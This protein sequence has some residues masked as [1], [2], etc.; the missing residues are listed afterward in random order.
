MFAPTNTGG[1]PTFYVMGNHDH[2]RDH[3][4]DA[5]ETYG[6]DLTNFN[7]Y[8]QRA[9]EEMF[10]PA[11]YS[12]N[13]GDVHIVCMR[14]SQWEQYCLD[15]NTSHG[16]YNHGDF[17]TDQVEWL[18]QDLANVPED[19]MVIFC[20]HIPL[21]EDSTYPGNQKVVE[22]LKQR[23]KVKIL[24]GHKHYNFSTTPSQKWHGFDEVTITGNWGYVNTKCGI[25][26]VPYGFDVYDFS[27]P[28]VAKNYFRACSSTLGVEGEGYQMRAYWSD[29]VSGKDATSTAKTGW[30]GSGSY[31]ATSTSTSKYMYVNIFNGNADWTV[32]LKIYNLSTGN[33]VR[34]YDM[35]RMA[36][37][38]NGT[39]GTNGVGTKAD[40][41]TLS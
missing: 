26:G 38:E 29:M 15:N 37:A 41:Y 28:S 7:F 27:G 10:A 30:Y 25:D 19:K 18:R 33:L 11:D 4:D 13:R 5:K 23:S 9:F 31:Y 35:S 20:I 17:T 16:S 34:T 8:A 39:W 2:E 3:F 6:S 12:F 40:P 22:V 1:V 24:S 36:G 14:N 32:K 21:R